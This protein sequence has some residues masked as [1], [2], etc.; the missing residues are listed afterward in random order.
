MYTLQQL[1]QVP[2]VMGVIRQYN[3]PGTEFS[4]FYGLDLKAAPK[5]VL[6]KRS[7]LYDIFNPT[8][9]MPTAR[10]N[11]TGPAR[12][13]RKPVGQMAVHTSRF[14]EALEINFE[15]VF[16]TRPI[17]GQ[18][19]TVD[20]HGRSYIKRQIQHELDKFGNLH[21]FLAFQMMRGGWSL[22]AYNGG[23]DLYPVL[24]GDS[25]A[26]VTVDSLVPSE[27]Q[28]QLA[29]DAGDTDV[30]D[31][32]WDDPAAPIIQQLMRL[33]KI[34]AV[35]HG[36]PLRHIWLNGTTASY[37]MENTQLRSVAGDAYLLYELMSNRPKTEGQTYEDTGYDIVF[38]ALPQI[39]FHVY[40]QAYIPGLVS[41]SFAAQTDASN[42]K[43]YIP[44]G[45][46]IITPHPGDWCE[47]IA[48]TEPM[49]HNAH[50]PVQY[51]SGFHMGR[52]EAYDPPRVDL[53]FLE[54][55]A[56]IITQYNAV[57]NPTVIFE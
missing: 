35:R 21:E 50:E 55:Y 43:Y 22:R 13:A 49:R 14:F 20:E 44:D 38:K 6:H 4:R 57:Y 48:G 40:N 7:G 31:V 45:E 47:K 53:R 10:M 11:M 25:E 5:Q 28:G 46:A 2:V 12:V 19:G 29:V 52:S 27:H 17:G 41:E 54:N 8:R 34:H 18:I 30:I 15:D 26:V 51:V 56:P 33:D 36:A 23:E 32:S 42:I 37:L 1:T 39:R 24:K 3:A 16:H 9:T